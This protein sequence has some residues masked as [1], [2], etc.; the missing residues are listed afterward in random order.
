[1]I[2]GTRKPYMT[3]RIFLFEFI[4][5]GGL[6]GQP[7]P[8][9]LALEGAL[10]LDALLRD[11]HELDGIEVLT[12][13][14]ARLPALTSGVAE[15]I[16]VGS[17][18]DFDRRF[19]E[20]LAAADAVLLVAPETGDTLATLTARV[21]AAGRLLLGC[22]AASCGIATSKS[23]TAAR[24]SAAGIA[25]LPHYAN[26][27]RLPTVPGRWVVKPDDGAGCDGLQL[28]VD[29]D[30]AARALRAAGPGHVAQPWMAGE[31]RSMNLLC[32][33][34]DALLLSINRQYL[35][36]DG[37]HVTLAALGVGEVHDEAGAYRKLASR[38]AAALPGLLGHVGVDLLHT[39]DGPVVVE[40]NPRLSTSACALHTACGY[41]L[42]A[43]T[44]AAA[45]GEALRRPPAPMRPQR[46]EL[47]PHAEA[48]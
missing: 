15:V 14:D 47:A 12:L 5:G 29:R 35:S 42:L 28:C 40:I 32:A 11:A 44:L 24:L 4:T 34:G 41:N 8:A 18:D 33:H 46:I 1:M 23:Q 36:H 3:H 39:A 9:S 38:I 45:R 25:V 2:S 13:R 48:A 16:P 37:D 26:A 7:L 17:A 31:A 19:D 20:A 43:A 10:M 21:E 30:A 6:A 22:D 27:S